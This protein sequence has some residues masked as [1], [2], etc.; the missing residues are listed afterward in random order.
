[1]VSLFKPEG[2]GNA[3]EMLE[4]LKLRSLE[5]EPHRD[6]AQAPEE[7]MSPGWH[8][9]LQGGTVILAVSTGK[10]TLDIQLILRGGTGTAGVGGI[11]GCCSPHCRETTEQ[12]LSPSYAPYWQSLA[13]SQLARQKWGLPSPQHHQAECRISASKLRV[14]SLITGTEACKHI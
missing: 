4:L 2:W 7:G 12:T 3:G 13:G 14:D 6:G 9:C 5:E 10:A 11:A 8:W 1:M